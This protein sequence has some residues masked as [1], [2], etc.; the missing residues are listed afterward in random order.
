VEVDLER[1]RDRLGRGANVKPVDGIGLVRDIVEDLDFCSPETEQKR[2][3]D[4]DH[5][6]ED[7]IAK[8]LQ[9]FLKGHFLEDV[10]F[11]GDFGKAGNPWFG[12]FQLVEWQ[13]LECARHDVCP[14][15]ESPAQSRAN[16]DYLWSVSARGRTMYLSDGMDD[17]NGYT[18][19]RNP[20]TGK[21][22]RMEI[23]FGCC[24]VV[25]SRVI[26]VHG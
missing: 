2:R 17:Q 12:W 20:G 18:V 10:G 21:Q 9:V 4:G 15:P 16:N 8:F 24:E 1:H 11:V 26:Y 22:Y 7:A 25:R 13:V 3:N 14:S 19:R 5:D 6:F 23:R